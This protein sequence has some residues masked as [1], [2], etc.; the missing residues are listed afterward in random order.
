MK[1]QTKD[2]YETL[3]VKKDASAEEIKKAYRKLALK[4]HPDK[5]PGNP[6]AE[7]RFKEAAEAYEVLSDPERRRTYDA[8]GAAGLRDMGFEGFQTFSTDDIFSHFGDVFSDFFGMGGGMRG[9]RGRRTA[10]A[11]RGSDV[12]ATLNVSFEEA[13]LGAKKEVEI[14]VPA[15]GGR[16]RSISL[17][18]PA[19]IESGGI[20]RLAGKGEP[21]LGGGPPGDLL[22]EV[23]V[24]PHPTLSR[25]GLDV[26]SSVRVPLATAVLGG[27]VEVETLRG[28]VKLKV[29][30]GT[31]SDALLRLR[32]KGIVGPGHSGDHL[33]RVVVTVPKTVSP[34]LERALRSVRE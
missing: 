10:F 4:H 26:R 2:Y 22:V 21:G 32:G 12:R 19:G 34:E 9:G 23:E 15:Q 16:G 29:P 24:E 25:D 31:S 17:T 3:G 14:P 27:E 33:V 1:T 5:N 6:D 11:R 8:R 7:R 28:T 20:L 13:A 18:I 30:R